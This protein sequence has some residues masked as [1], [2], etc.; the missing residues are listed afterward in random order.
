MATVAELLAAGGDLPGEAPRRDAEVLLCHCLDKPRSYLYAWPDAAVEDVAA[1][2]YLALLA[3]RRRGE[4]IAY[5]T[6][7]R[8]FWSLPLRVTRD[9]LIPRPD[10]ETL[11][12]WALA[13][14]LPPAARVLDLGTGSG[15]IA[16]ALASERAGWTVTAIDRSAAALAVAAENGRALGLDNAGF[17]QSD[18]FS[19]LAGRR[20][21]LV[22]SNPP[23][24]DPQ[25]SH[26]GR[27]DLRFE[28]RLALVA[29]G[30]GLAAIEQ[31][32]AAAPAHLEPG[33]WLLLEHGCEQGEAVRSL[34]ARLGL[35]DIETRCD[36]AGLERVSGG[37]THAE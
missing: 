22:V 3:A 33:G 20:Y 29:E 34:L 16:L 12:A 19:A 27:G 14:P 37:R 7:R 13:L 9:T 5:L 18:W 21:H 35:V 31:I 25:D 6:G 1:E 23:Y 17:L 30:Q 36:L 11:V 10:T 2:R 15:A 32:A 26:L 24:I 28:P 8:E 4:P